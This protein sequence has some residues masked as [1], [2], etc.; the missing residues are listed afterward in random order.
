[1]TNDGA[2]VA[3]GAAKFACFSGATGKIRKFGIA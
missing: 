1:M 3:A 2:A